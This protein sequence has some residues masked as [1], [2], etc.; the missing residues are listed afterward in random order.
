V[1]FVEYS[2]DGKQNVTMPANDEYYELSRTPIL[3]T[4]NFSFTLEYLSQGL[5]TLAVYA[6]GVYHYWNSSGDYFGNSVVGSSSQI[7]FYI[8]NHVSPRIMNLSPSNE[9]YQKTN[10]PLNFTVNEPTSWIGY[11][12]DGKANV[13]IAGNTTL[14]ALAYGEH[15]LIIYA[16][17]TVGNMGASKSVT[18]TV[19]AFPTATVIAV[20]VVIA[21]VVS[22]GIAVFYRRHRKNR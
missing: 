11:S 9:T 4:L 8:N 21:T 19:S 10:V 7:G 12:L 15:I 18:F 2:I 22:I 13:T 3:N 16:N 17:D 14:T 20:S 6:Q 1:Y 5:H